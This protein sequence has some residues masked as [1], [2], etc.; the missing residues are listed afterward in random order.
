MPRLG[1]QTLERKEK[2]R[3]ARKF[4]EL[5]RRI[6]ERHEER[7]PLNQRTLGPDLRPRSAGGHKNVVQRLSHHSSSEYSN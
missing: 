5:L 1:G 7:A 6:K 3:K 2:K 4:R